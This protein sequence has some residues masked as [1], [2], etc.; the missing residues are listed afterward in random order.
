MIG[1]VG[2]WSGG[3]PPGRSNEKRLLV[4]MSGHDGDLDEDTLVP[5]VDGRAPEAEP[6][7]A[8]TPDTSEPPDTSAPFDVGS[9]DFASLPVAPFDA[10]PSDVPPP[11]TGEPPAAG[12][13]DVPRRWPRVLGITLAAVVVLGG[14]Y[15]AGSWALAGQVPRGTTVAGIRIGGQDTRTATA[16]LTSGL[17]RLVR[18]PVPLVAGKVSTTIV[19]AD[20]G[21]AVDVDATVRA[22]TSFDLSPVQLWY[23]LFGRGA[24]PPVTAV[25]TT[26][27]SA[28]MATVAAALATEPVDGQVVFTDNAAHATAAVDGVAVDSGRAATAVRTTWLT[29]HRPLTV[30]TRAV[31]PAITQKEADRA[32]AAVAVPLAR[33]PIAVAV[34]GQTVEL[35]VAVVTAHASF[36]AQH[37]ALVLALDG[38]GLVAEVVKRTTGVFTPPADATFAFVNAAPVI[39]PG[40]AGT[41]ID[42][43]ALVTAVTAAAVAADR[44]A[45]VQLVATDP[46][47]SAAKLQ[48]LGIT[49]IIAQFATPLIPEPLRTKNL[50]IGASKVNGTL[51]LPGETFSLTKA[52]GPVTLA[53]GFID[54]GVIVDGQHVQGVGGGLSQLST[55]TFNAAYFAGFGDVEHTPHS[56]WFTRYPEGRE[57][58]IYIGSIDMKFKNT[59]PTGALV[60]AWLAGNQV[61]VAIWGTPYWT[62][63]TSTSA[64]SNVV[65]PT[66]V[67]STDPTCTRQSAGN[68]GFTVTVTRRLLLSGALKE[69]TSRT[70]RYQPQNA[71][72]CDAPTG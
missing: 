40:K 45:R 36:V 32:L 52:L 20:A 68:P 55:T 38:P 5:V 60:Q 18:E 21:L 11:D 39:V 47:Q 46:A 58:T 19:P 14:A 30:P 70:T 35:P 43:A 27:F 63:Q 4:T 24:L 37:S 10:P 49:Q 44:T 13:T 61:H 71:I 34:A 9:F 16:S 48:G 17:A 7:P 62:V 41:T 25:D 28:A 56:E 12:Q 22:A 6:A 59:A 67:H 2:S 3:G 54:A 26:K 15:V 8:P 33:A 66:T 42:P 57:A 53:A 50:T 65:A 23:H 64:R 31:R 51:V 29:A 69:T 1:P 72:I